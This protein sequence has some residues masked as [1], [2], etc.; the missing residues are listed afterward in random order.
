MSSAFMHR[1]FSRVGRLH[2]STADMLMIPGSLLSV[3]EIDWYIWVRMSSVFDAAA[4]T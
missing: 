3:V 2:A 4:A 1:A